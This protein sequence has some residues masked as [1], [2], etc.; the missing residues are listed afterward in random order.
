MGKKGTKANRNYPKHRVAAFKNC[1]MRN[2]H[3]KMEQFADCLIPVRQ[4]YILC[5]KCKN[6]K[7]ITVDNTECDF[8]HLVAN[9]C[10][11]CKTNEDSYEELYVDEE[12]RPVSF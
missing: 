8:H 6:K 10:P 7:H 4:T 1:I 12:G 5:N 9:Y 3:K 2:V 11:K